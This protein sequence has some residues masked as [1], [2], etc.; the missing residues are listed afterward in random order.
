MPAAV[1]AAQPRVAAAHSP[2]SRTLAICYD[3]SGSHRPTEFKTVSGTKL[4]LVTY[5]RTKE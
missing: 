3:L 5:L 2:P 1:G 4:Y